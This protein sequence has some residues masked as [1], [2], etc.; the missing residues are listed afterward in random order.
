MIA[1]VASFFFPIISFL[2]C[3]EPKP[4]GRPQEIGI[5]LTQ[6]TR[7]QTT[8]CGLWLDLTLYDR[9]YAFISYGPALLLVSI[10]VNQSP[11]AKKRDRHYSARVHFML[12]PLRSAWVQL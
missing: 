10:G 5:L 11:M 2:T 9:R 3:W 7:L 12:G 6:E 1:A 4:I 8:S